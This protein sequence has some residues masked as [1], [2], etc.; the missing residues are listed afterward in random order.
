M[1]EGVVM[2]NSARFSWALRARWLASTAVSLSAASAAA[3]PPLNTL[4]DFTPA[5]GSAFEFS[6]LIQAS[7]GNFY[8]VSALGGRNE[9]G[10]VYK[11]NRTTG[12]ITHLHDFDFSDGATPRGSLIQGA[13]G[14][15]YGTTEAGGA[16]RSDYCYSGQYYQKGGCGTAFKVSLT[17]AFTKLHDFYTAADGYQAATN[18]GVIQASDGN[19]YGMAQVEFP[20][21]WSSVF[22]MTPG[23]VVTPFFQFAADN[24]QGFGTHTGLIQ[25][26]DGNLY[27]TTLG[28][29]PSAAEYGTVFRLSLSG[30]FQTLYLFQ[31]AP[32]SGIGD[33]AN[34]WGNLIEGTDGALYGTTYGGGTTAGNCYDGGCGTVFRITTAGDEKVLYRFTGSA[35]DGEWPQNAG[36][37]WVSDDTLYGVSSGNPYGVDGP[38]ECYVGSIATAGCGIVF[39]LTTAGKFTALH[40]FG[41]GD[42]SLGLFPMTSMILA[43]DNNLYGVA[44]LGG[45]YGDGTVYRVQRNAA[46]PVLEIS[47]IAPAGGPPGTTV[48]I[49]GK[50]FTG[51]S[52]VTFPTGRATPVPFTVQSDTEIEISVPTNGVSGAIGVTAPH[53]TTF[54]PVIFY[55]E[56]TISSLVPTRGHIGGSVNILGT[57]FDDITSITIGGATVTNWD[58]VTGGDTSIDAEIPEGAVTGPIVITNPGGSAISQVFTITDASRQTH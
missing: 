42:G 22:K 1:D 53:G 33:G 39:E 26:T 25:A 18:T 44:L 40:N 35:T 46:T 30:A 11:V 15:L 49:S 31:G 54:S 28:L 7:D 41:S 34:P 3:V 24:S 10:F 16:N 8:G 55:L 14:D 2:T 6:A 45:G 19:F 43:S 50:G 4:Y 58:F 17:G 5:D 36:L 37:A 52:Q 56:P 27:G 21:G 29:S 20:T 48:V 38:P 13:D 57:H 47:G 51:A 23:G 9:E 12:R 32:A